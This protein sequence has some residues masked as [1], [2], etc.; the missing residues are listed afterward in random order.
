MPILA[1]G[2]FLCL[3]LAA[4]SGGDGT[5]TPEQNRQLANTEAMLNA[6][7]VGLSNIDE[8]GLGDANADGVDKNQ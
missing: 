2:P 7:P 8:N 5:P 6:A 1:C 3:L 4:C